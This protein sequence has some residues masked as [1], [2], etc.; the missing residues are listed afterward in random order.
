MYSKLSESILWEKMEEYYQH[1]GPSLWQTNIV[2]YAISSSKILAQAYANMIIANLQDYLRDAKLDAPNEP[3]YVLELGAGHG[4]FGYYLTKKL[5]SQF[6]ILNWSTD[7]VKYILTDISEENKLSWSK[8]PNF[9]ELIKS[10]TVD[11]ATLNPLLG[12]NF[13]TDVQKFEFKNNCTNAPLFVIGNYFFDSLKQDAFEVKD[14]KISEV[15]IDVNTSGPIE[16][17]FEK[18]NYT[19]KRNEIEPNSYYNNDKLNKILEGYKKDLNEG[20]FLLPVGAINCMENL[21]GLSSSNVVFLVGDKGET[22]LEALSYISD[23]EISQHGSISM[24][25]NFHAIE[26]YFNLSEGMAIT[27][28]NTSENFQLAFFSSRYSYSM[29][30]TAYSFRNLLNLTSPDD[31]YNLFYTN[32]NEI[33]EYK[34]LDQYIALM[35]VSDWDPNL[36]YEIS[37]DLNEMLEDLDVVQD[38]TIYNGLLKVE[39]YFFKV[40]SDSDIFFEVG[41]LL[42]TLGRYTDAIRLFKK[43]D[44]LFQD[45]SEVHYN[46]A[47]CYEALENN[48]KA[49]EHLRACLK[50]NPTYQPAVELDQEIA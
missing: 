21:Y 34:S 1:M 27:T 44:E 18:S 26:Q 20:S 8:H 46:L 17:I 22:I 31:I 14:G 5:I 33:I 15:L 47:L 13:Y 3:V 40:E 36:L 25:V 35:K 43:S 28:T 19:Y 49:K 4:Q 12:E 48:E 41:N 42:Y 6:T 11:F 16:S 2:P 38:N 50:E 45:N 32:Y 39:E 9:Q 24:M 37:S 10:G 23:P 30:N 7:Y 29:Y